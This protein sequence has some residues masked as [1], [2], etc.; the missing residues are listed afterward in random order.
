MNIIQKIRGDSPDRAFWAA[1]DEY[2]TAK[3]RIADL[4]TRIEARRQAQE[5]VRQQAISTVVSDP[6]Q[7]PEAEGILAA[8]QHEIGATETLL[9]GVQGQLEQKTN[10]LVK[11]RADQLIAEA[12]QA[13]AE[14]EKVHTKAQQH[15]SALSRLTGVTYTVSILYAQPEGVDWFTTAPI[16]LIECDPGE[17][18]A[19][20]RTY[21]KPIT[22]SLRQRALDL[23]KQA[24]DLLAARPGSPAYRDTLANILNWAEQQRTA[25]A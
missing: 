17:C 7:I 8:L 21:A 20:I 23:H 15:L 4:T 18:V 19:H 12:A 14:V 16:P 24:A 10:I 2:A 11:L 1:F 13:E 25:A 9:A 3:Q 5:Q 6:G 22:R